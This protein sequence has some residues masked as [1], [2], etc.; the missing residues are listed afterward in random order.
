M[1]ALRIKTKILTNGNWC[2]PAYDTVH[3]AGM[4]LRAA[5]TEG[6]TLDMAPGDIQIVPTGLVLAIPDGFEVQI[7]PRSALA[8]MHGVTVLNSPGTIDCGCGEEVTVILINHGRSAFQI[9]RG[10]HIA[11]LV[12]APVVQA[13]LV[14]VDEL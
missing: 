2:H 6:A 11:Q 4:V 7:R 12:I 14:I 5:I 9:K 13:E 8:A 3:E 1:Q 10:D